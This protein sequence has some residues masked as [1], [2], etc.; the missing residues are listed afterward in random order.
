M[1]DMCKRPETTVDEKW[2]WENCR[3]TIMKLG[4]HPEYKTGVRVLGYLLRS[5]GIFVDEFNDNMPVQEKRRTQ[6]LYSILTYYTGVAPIPVKNSVIKFN[7]LAGG[8]AKAAFSDQIEREMKIYFDKDRSRV[9]H[10]FTEVFH[11]RPV[12][13][14]DLAF[15]ID[16]LPGFP[17]T[18]V[19]HAADDE[20]P[21]EFKIFFDATAN[22][23]LPTEIC[24]FLI[25]IF[26]ERLE[27]LWNKVR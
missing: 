21:S 22:H 23:Y 11:A 17:V 16:F 25:D 3:G 18:F 14:G 2:T 13:Y 7:Q 8:V 20:L 6:Y 9:S 26:V 1:G 15:A 10:I 27:S 24:D 4:N 5:D 19:Y 12:S